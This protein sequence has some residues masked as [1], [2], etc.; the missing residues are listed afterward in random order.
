MSL[1][2]DTEL[3]GAGIEKFEC[4][5]VV[6]LVESDAGMEGFREFLAARFVFEFDDDPPLPDSVI[7]QSRGFSYVCAINASEQK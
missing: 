1:H 2:L 4:L 7:L 5:L 3:V 6:D